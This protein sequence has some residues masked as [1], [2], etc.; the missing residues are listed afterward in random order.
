MLT[1]IAHLGEPYDPML[2][3]KLAKEYSFADSQQ[4]GQSKYVYCGVKIKGLS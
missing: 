3:L 4:D 1:L 2:K